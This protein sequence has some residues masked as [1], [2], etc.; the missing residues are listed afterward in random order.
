MRLRLRSWQQRKKN[1]GKQWR[2]TCPLP[3]SR[4]RTKTRTLAYLVQSH[5]HPRCMTYVVVWVPSPLSSTVTRYCLDFKEKNFLLFSICSFI[6]FKW[7]SLYQPILIWM[8]LWLPKKKKIQCSNLNCCDTFF[9]TSSVLM[10][11]VFICLFLHLLVH[12]SALLAPNALFYVQMAMHWPKLD[13]NFTLWF[14][15]T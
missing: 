15:F 10:V 3:L 4:S 9:F 7:R 6:G 8:Y 1:W 14:L 11:C 5:G 12:N 13:Y 2:K